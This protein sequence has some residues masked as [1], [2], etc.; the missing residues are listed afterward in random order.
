MSNINLL[1]VITRGE[2]AEFD[3][4]LENETF[5]RSKDITAF[6]KFKA[7]FPTEGG[8]PLVITEVTNANGSSITK[9]DGGTYG[10]LKVVLGPQDSLLL[11]VDPAQDIDIEWDIAASPAPKR[12]RLSRDLNVE[13]SICT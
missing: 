12:K 8:T 11:K 7:C 9:V 13:D 5:P 10:Q 6:D 1:T 2:K 4:F 3:I